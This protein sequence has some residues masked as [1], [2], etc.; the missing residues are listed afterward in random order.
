MNLFGVEVT[1]LDIEA[2]CVLIRVLAVLV[3]IGTG[4]AFYVWRKSWIGLAGTLL[5][6]SLAWLGANYPLQRPSC[7]KTRPF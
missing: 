2:F 1:H 6:V 5:L 3:G 4:L 7:A